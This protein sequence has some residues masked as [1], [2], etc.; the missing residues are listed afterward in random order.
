MLLENLNK[1]REKNDLDPMTAAAFAENGMNFSVEMETGTGKTYVYLRAI[2]ALHQK[3]GSK[4]FIIVVPL[5]PASNF[6]ICRALWLLIR[7][8]Q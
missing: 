4:K 6:R 2:Y 1:I 3:Y 5:A 8:L 7:N